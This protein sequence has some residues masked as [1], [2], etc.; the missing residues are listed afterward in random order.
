MILYDAS[1]TV[2]FI[3]IFNE[4]QKYKIMVKLNKQTFIALLSF[5]RSMATKCISL[6]NEQ[7]LARTTLY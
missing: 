3:N 4:K 1:D 6:N 2:D 7:C 5:S